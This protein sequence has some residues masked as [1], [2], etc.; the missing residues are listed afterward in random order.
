[1][2]KYVGLE[3][4]A[5]EAYEVE[6]FKINTGPGSGIGSMRES[7]LDYYKKSPLE[8]ATSKVIREDNWADLAWPD[9]LGRQHQL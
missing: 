5:L 6:Y 8:A 7:A 3:Q 4:D 2:F 1:M 9:F